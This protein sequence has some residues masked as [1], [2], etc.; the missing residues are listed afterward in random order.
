MTKNM[1]A[2]RNQKSEAEKD[3]REST[4]KIIDL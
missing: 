3:L 2:F 4:A 1:E